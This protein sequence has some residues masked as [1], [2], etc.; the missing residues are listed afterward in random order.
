[1]KIINILPQN[2]NGD[3]L[4]DKSIPTKG[5]LSSKHS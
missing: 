1:M 3:E 5:Q 2:Y 4:L